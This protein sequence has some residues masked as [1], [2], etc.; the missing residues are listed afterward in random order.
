M[1]TDQ[2]L[3]LARKHLSASPER[4]SSARFCLNDA[5]RAQERGDDR[6]TRMW[7][8]KSL[9]YSIGVLHPDYAKAAA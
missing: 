8:L 4:E 2:I 3:A 7:A 5:V 6:A 9:G 1:T